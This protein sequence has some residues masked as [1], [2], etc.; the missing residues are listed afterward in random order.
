V[1]LRLKLDVDRF[2]ENVAA[3]ESSH[4]VRQFSADAAGIRQSFLRDVENAQHEL[5][6]A[7]DIARED[8]AVPAALKV[9]EVTLPSQLDTAVQL[10]DVEDW[11]AV[12]LRLKTQIQQLSELSSTLVANV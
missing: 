12:R 10:A 2:G 9:L 3:L 7:P 11:A 8:P 6:R 1:L 4:D 5:S